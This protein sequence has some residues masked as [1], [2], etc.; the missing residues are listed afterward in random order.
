MYNFRG[1]YRY[2]LDSKGRINIPAKFRTKRDS[3][4]PEE[5]VLSRGMD[6]AIILQPKERWEEIERKLDKTDLNK[7]KLRDFKRYLMLDA[8]E[9]VPDKQGRVT[10]SGNLLEYANIEKNVVI[11]GMISYI[12]IWRPEL[13]DRKIEEIKNSFAEIAEDLQLEE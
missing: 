12:E 6:E 5:F 3:D 9:V 4:E 10:I 1:T 7:R 11:H 13:F 2:N 8:T